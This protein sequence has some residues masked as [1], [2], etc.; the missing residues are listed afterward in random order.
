MHGGRGRNEAPSPDAREKRDLPGLK[1]PREVG[2]DQGAAREA[3]VQKRHPAVGEDGHGL[4]AAERE[5]EVSLEKFRG[6][7][8]AQ[9]V[10]RLDGVP[11]R[12][13]PNERRGG[14]RP[15]EPRRFL[16]HPVEDDGGDR[17]LPL[18]EGFGI[19]VQRPPARGRHRPA[20]GGV[21]TAR[22]FLS[23]LRAERIGLRERK[24]ALFKLSAGGVGHWRKPRCVQRISGSGGMFCRPGLLG[25]ALPKEEEPRY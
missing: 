7:A 3:H 6:E 13:L 24:E 5:E 12:E 8:R 14:V 23:R 1:R 19:G 16:L 22:Q 11:A 21:K 18:A 25:R 9:V 2:C 17:G 20:D 15:V 4:L 10:R